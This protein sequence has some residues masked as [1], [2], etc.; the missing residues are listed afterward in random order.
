[1]TYQEV[2]RVSRRSDDEI[3]RACLVGSRVYGTAHDESDHDYV[4]ILKQEV[5]QNQLIREGKI[6]VTVQSLGHFKDGIS[7]GNV[8]AHEVLCA[9][10][11]YVLKNSPFNLPR[12]WAKE[13]R[14]II[15]SAIEKATNDFKKGANVHDPKRIYHAFRVLNFAQ[16][17]FDFGTIRDFTEAKHI[18]EVVMTE[19]GLFSFDFEMSFHTR[20]K[21]LLSKLE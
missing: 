11:A 14:N 6:N 19:P 16:Q 9:P 10:E 5:A 20:T 2:L 12:I 13:R 17:L 18:Y 21:E 15:E 3:H 4:L 1:M 8:F 7:S